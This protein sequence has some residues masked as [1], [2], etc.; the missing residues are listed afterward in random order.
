MSKRLSTSWMPVRITVVVILTLL[1]FSPASAQLVASTSP[2]APT[3]PQSWPPDPTSEI[4]WS[5]GTSTVANIQ[6]AF[7]NAH[8]QE[9]AQ[10]GLSLPMLTMPSQTEWNA[11]SDGDKALWLINH[12]R[13]ARGVTP[14]HAVEF[15]VTS[16]AQNYASYLLANDAFSHTADGH[17]PI[18]RLN[19]N[20]TISACHDFLPIA[21]NLS[22]F[23]TSGSSIPLPIERSIYLWMYVD[24]GGSNWGHRHAILYYPY[25]ENGG[26]P[27]MEGFLGIGRAHGPHQG[28]N[29]AEIIVM[30]V[31]DPCASWVYT[32]GEN[33]SYLPM[34]RK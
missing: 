11:M 27:T 26:L 15:N 25:T 13:Q 8:N 33:K 2:Q 4:A 28:W 7:N 10:L 23:W 34:I 18:W 5:G 3:D 16:V 14:L 24:G 1:G 22:V 21:E 6:S 31:F 19:A 12:E 17:N 9:N 32:L 20:P 30:N 29:Y